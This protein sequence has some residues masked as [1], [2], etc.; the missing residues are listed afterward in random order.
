MSSIKIG[1][2]QQPLDDVSPGWITQ[3]IERR[4]RDGIAV[5]VEVRIKEADLDMSLATPGC[6]RNGGWGR[7]PNVHEKVIFDLWQECGLNETGFASGRVIEF[8]ARLK[9]LL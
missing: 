8:L 6:S 4:R 3:Q 1:N 7:R 5:C 9:R 2:D